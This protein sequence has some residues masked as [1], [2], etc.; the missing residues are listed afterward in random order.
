MERLLVAA[1]VVST[2]CL[3]TLAQKKG[4]DDLNELIKR[5]Y[6][7]WGTLNPQQP[8]F[9]RANEADLVSFTLLP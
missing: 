4:V 5:Y 3:P 1:L 9:F 2:L 6:V 7:P 8:L